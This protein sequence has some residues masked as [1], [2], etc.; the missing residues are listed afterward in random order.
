MITKSYS[1][2]IAHVKTIENK[3]GKMVGEFIIVSRTERVSLRRHLGKRP[4]ASKGG[5]HLNI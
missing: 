3:S 2:S 5:S 4:E 1:I